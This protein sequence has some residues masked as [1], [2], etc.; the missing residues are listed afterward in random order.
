MREQDLD[1]G[2]TGFPSEYLEDWIG[3]H[4]GKAYCIPRLHL[5]VGKLKGKGRGGHVNTRA[6]FE[7]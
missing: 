1:D 3:S 2:L 7:F 4:S 5:G 6:L